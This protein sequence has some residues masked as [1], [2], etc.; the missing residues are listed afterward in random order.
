MVDYA[1]FQIGL[2][3]AQASFL[4]TVHGTCQI[5]G[6]LTILP[7]SDY[8]SRRKTLLISN[9]FIAV[10]ILGILLF[11]EVPGVLGVLVGILAVF[12]GATFPLY[13]ACA[14][15]YFPKE[16]M[17]TVI[18]AWTPFYGVGAILVHWVSGILRDKTGIYDHAFLICVVM[19]VLGIFF[20][21]KTSR[22]PQR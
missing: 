15:D 9:T 14:G 4:A 1:R 3:L 21:M 10:S 18:G 19:A 11:G 12:Y 8:I 20:L 22:N 5:L 7:L 2:P 16:V 13:G 17:G 6:V